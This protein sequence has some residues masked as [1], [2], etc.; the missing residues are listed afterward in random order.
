MALNKRCRGK[1]ELQKLKKI[2]KNILLL[3]QITL[4]IRTDLFNNGIELIC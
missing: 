1:I 4:K 2:S 3:I